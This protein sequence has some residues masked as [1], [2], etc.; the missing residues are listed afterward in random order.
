MVVVSA[1]TDATR[2]LD[3]IWSFIAT[4][5]L[6]AADRFLDHIWKRCQSYANQPM[7]GEMRSDPG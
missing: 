5:N 6:D 7:P 1:S 2:D 4:D 3:Q